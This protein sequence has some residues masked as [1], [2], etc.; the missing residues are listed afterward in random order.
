MLHF[1]LFFSLSFS[2]SLSLSLVCLSVC[3][4]LSLPFFPYHL[5]RS[6]LCPFHPR[7]A[8]S[9]FPFPFSTTTSHSP[10]PYHRML[11]HLEATIS[12]RSNFDCRATS[13]PAR[14]T[15]R[16]IR[17]PRGSFSTNPPDFASSYPLNFPPLN[18]TPSPKALTPSFL[19]KL[20]ELLPGVTR[21]R[22]F[23]RT[24]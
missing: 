13:S 3:L 11:S 24:A 10:P 9:S 1:S 20:A 5:N 12:I 8:A 7:S 18:F 21:P 22:L 4:S 19:G 23:N 17:Y 14:S 6:S 2:F 16:P 15:D